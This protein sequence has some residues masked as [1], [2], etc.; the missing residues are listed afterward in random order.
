MCLSVLLALGIVLLH[1]FIVLVIGYLYRPIILLLEQRDEVHCF[2]EFVVSVCRPPIELGLGHL[3]RHF[4]TI[5]FN[6]H[7]TILHP[8]D[9]TLQRIQLRLR[10]HLNRHLDL[11]SAHVPTPPADTLLRLLQQDRP[12]VL[13]QHRAL[14]EAVDAHVALGVRG[15]AALLAA[16][17]AQDRTLV[18]RLQHALALRRR[19]GRLHST[20]HACHGAGLALDE[21]S[22]GLGTECTHLVVRHDNVDN[23]D[24]IGNRELASLHEKERDL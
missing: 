3:L 13:A 23:V 20:R 24:A 14:H 22:A 5:L 10:G 8:H 18:S 9:I 15:R 4:K 7:H 19:S 12:A 2:D 1:G 21:G 16:L 17:A 11:L 6:R